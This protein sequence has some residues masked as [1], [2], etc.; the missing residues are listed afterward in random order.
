MGAI[1]GE[2]MP[3][4]ETEGRELKPVTL[5]ISKRTH[6]RLWVAK[7]VKGVDM[8]ALAERAI[9]LELRKLNL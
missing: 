6:A 7:I 5:R 8:Q 4:T 1:I 3:E 9:D 2:L